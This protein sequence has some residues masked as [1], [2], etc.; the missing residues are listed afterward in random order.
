MIDALATIGLF[1]MVAFSGALLIFVCHQ[2]R[3]GRLRDIIDEL[4]GELKQAKLYCSERLLVINHP[5]DLFGRMDQ[6]W[7]RANGQLVISDTKTRQVIRYYFSDRLQLTGYAFLLKYH[8]ETK[9]HSIASYGYLRIPQGSKAV[10]I[11]VPLLSEQAYREHVKRYQALQNGLARPKPASSPLIC[12]DCGHIL[13][14][15]I[16]LINRH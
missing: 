11:K 9:G 2:V 7:Q 14:C 3:L 8:P 1:L 5:V 16:P 15:P 12:R 6:I 10:Y 4:P 13:R